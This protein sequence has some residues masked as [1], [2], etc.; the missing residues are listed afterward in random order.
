MKDFIQKASDLEEQK[1]KLEFELD[2]QTNIKNNLDLRIKED[3]RLKKVAE[4]ALNTYQMQTDLKMK[5]M[6]QQN[7]ENGL[8]LEQKENEIQQLKTSVEEIKSLNSKDKSGAS[9]QNLLDEKNREILEL[10]NQLNEA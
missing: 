10:K 6:I 1:E 5:K 8:A 7:L 2:C 3:Q 4:E 9:S